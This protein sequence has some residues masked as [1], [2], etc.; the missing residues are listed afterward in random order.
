MDN[1]HMTSRLALL[2]ICV[3]ANNY[4]SDRLRGGWLFG[5]MGGLGAWWLIS[6]I[7]MMV[8]RYDGQ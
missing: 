1:R 6:M 3:M 5:M 7:G 2:L 4:D 8:V